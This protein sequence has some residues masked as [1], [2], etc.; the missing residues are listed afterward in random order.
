MP[1]FAVSTAFKA[2]DKVTQTFKR[3]GKGA[4]KF[5][6]QSSKAFQRASKSASIFGK[7]AKRVLSAGILVGGILLV[8]RGIGEVTRE[9]VSFDQA[10]TAS[11]AKFKDLRLNT[12]AGQKTLLELK[13]TARDVGAVTQFTATEA[14]GGLDFLAMAGF[15]AAQSMALLPG[16]VDLATVANVDLARSTDIA[17][18]TLGAFGLM[19]DDTAQLTKNFARVNDVMAKTMVSANADME[20]IFES[21]KKGAPS[22]TAAG[23]SMETF[24]AL[25]GVMANSGVKG[26]EAGTSLRNMMLRLADPS[27]EAQAVLDKLNI[28]TQDSQGNFRDIVDIIADFEKGLKGMG[29][30]QR[31][32]AL[33]TVFGARAVTGFNIILKEGTKSIRGYRG[34]LENAGGESER[35]A[36]IMRKSLGNRMKALGSAA[37]ELGFKFFTA[38]EKDGGGAIDS[39]T[40]AVRNF[41]VQP[42]IDG[43]KFTFSAIKSLINIITPWAPLMMEVVAAFVAYSVIMKTILGLKAAVAFLSIAKAITAINL[44]FAAN[45]IAFIVGGIVTAVFLLIKGLGLLQKKFKIFD[46]LAE[47]TGFKFIK[48]FGEFV[49]DPLGFVGGGIKAIAR[50]SRLEEKFSSKDRRTFKPPV[51][52]NQTEIEARQKIDFQGRVQFENAPAGTSVSGKTTGAP[53][54]GL[55]LLGVNP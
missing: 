25:L 29:T 41:N 47:S 26:A 22:F 32:A 30:Q 13:K 24:S 46:K 15:G 31:T 23:Q 49:I 4:D 10:I 17:S 14:A 35:M 21:V 5:G 54:I 34:E 51:A 44:A 3:M 39:L 1:T 37:I 55:E 9:F 53:P 38:F 36:A 2:I 19:T 27:K 7:T 33:S 16:V 48:S 52:P 18:D 28:T 50:Q 6:N 12:E 40:N 8:K 43:L 20:T 42:I 11:S 45:P